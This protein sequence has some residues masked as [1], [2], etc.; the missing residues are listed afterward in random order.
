MHKLVQL[1]IVGLSLACA[2][3]A[4]LADDWHTFD[5]QLSWNTGHLCNAQKKCFALTQPTF[6]TPLTA[7]CY[8]EQISTFRIID[9]PSGISAYHERPG[10]STSDRIIRFGIKEVT[11]GTGNILVKTFLVQDHG[12]QNNPCLG[13]F[14]GHAEITVEFY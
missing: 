14:G 13:G 11:F 3:S 1:F 4:G 2:L 7:D 9:V 5:A 12:G 8:R 10:N 6:G